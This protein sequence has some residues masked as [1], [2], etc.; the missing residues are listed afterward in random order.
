MNIFDALSLMGGLS[1]FLFGMNIMGQSLERRAG[2]KLQAL[3]GKF[4]TGKISGLLS[5]MLITA[6]IQSSSATTVMAVGFVN[7]HLMTLRQAINVI[8]GANIGT[9]VTAWILSLSGIDSGN[10]WI[11]L[12]KPSSFTPLLAT[13]G[14]I[15]YLFCKNA[16]KKDTGMILLGFATLMFGMET[17]SAAVSGLSQVPSFQQLFLLFQNPFLGVLAGAALTA[18]IQ[19]SSASVGI[20]QAL[21]STGQITYNAAIPIIMG[22]NIGTCITAILS[23]I[24]ANKNAKRTALVHLLFNVIGTAFCLLLFCTIKWSL[25]PSFLNASVSLLGIAL[26]HSAFNIL[27]TMLLFPLS[28]WLETLVIRLVPDAEQPESEIKLDERLLHTPPIALECC[29]DATADMA[30]TAIS[31]FQDACDMLLHHTPKLADTIHQKEK[32]VDHYEDML[33]TYLLH[34]SAKAISEDDNMEAVK[35]LKVI[36]DYERICDHA[37][38]LAQSADEMQEQNIALSDNARLELNTIINAVNEIIALSFHAFLANDIASA[39]MVEP[40]E[41]VIDALK[42]QIRTHHIMRLQRGKCSVNAGFIWSDI[43]TNL[44]RISDHCSNIA[45]C[46]IDIADHNM[47]LHDTLHA[48]RH[49]NPTFCDAYQAYAEKYAIQ[50]NI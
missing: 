18:L 14:I 2:G 21:A 42:E 34:L 39:H 12:L 1:L 30:K 50:S 40:L 41:Q 10:V 16:K 27:C 24:G 11:Q 36:G 15:C 49:D 3:L 4:T 25:H 13:V 47:H 23:A 5:G 31:A 17:M 19:S 9:T 6:V 43:L 22:Q 38:N 33:N 45:G 32:Q 44:E 35:L 46:V 48:L 26:A 8:I 29:H 37:L 28:G 7:S 20:L